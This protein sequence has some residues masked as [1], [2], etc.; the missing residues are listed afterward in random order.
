MSGRDRANVG[1]GCIV[2]GALLVLLAGCTPPLEIGA[3]G[4]TGPAVISLVRHL[5]CELATAYGN[6]VFGSGDGHPMQ[7][8]PDLWKR[9]YD[10]EF[11]AAVDLTLTVTHTQ[12]FNPS[13]SFM[14]PLSA[15]GTV[16]TTPNGNVLGS[17]SSSMF[18]QSLALGFQLDGTQDRNFDVQY[19]IDLHRLVGTIEQ[20][21][22]KDWKDAKDKICQESRGNG[23]MSYAAS[24]SEQGFSGLQGDLD[25]AETINDGLLVLDF[26]G[27]TNIYGT[28]GPTRTADEGGGAGTAIATA[29]QPPAATAVPT[30]AQARG[31]QESKLLDENVAARA[32]ELAGSGHGGGNTGGGAAG[33][34]GNATFSSKI[35]FSV[36]EG[37]N[38]GPNYSI[39]R[40]KGPGGGSG[41]GGGGGAGGAGGGA[42]GGGGGGGQLIS[43]NRTALDS[44]SVTFSPTCRVSKPF[45]LKMSDDAIS[46]KT[47]ATQS[48]WR[49]NYTPTSR[50]RGRFF[51]PTYDVT[52]TVPAPV[53]STGTG[54]LFTDASKNQGLITFEAGGKSFR[55][56]VQVSGYYDTGS[57][58][59]VT[60]SV[61]GK[62]SDPSSQAVV[63]VFSLNGRISPRGTSQW[64]GSITGNVVSSL[65]DTKP[66]ASYWDTIESCDV[67]TSGTT[68]TG[69][70]ARV[71]NAVQQNLLFR[72]PNRLRMLLG[73]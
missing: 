5:N 41:A 71:N 23:P 28:S 35:D 57:D 18:N 1:L 43:A 29:K 22:Q 53:P 8:D 40:F 47:E 54:V 27:R 69:V 45:T 51:P 14:T 37:I 44:L 25:L 34:A 66:T 4:N 26:T 3:G 42:A 13:L 60:A 58:K 7:T 10:D 19:I 49:F 67:L 48:S 63:G 72:L 50:E 62:I 61:N 12:G 32:A 52:I 55:G 16:L 33:Q 15:T 64:T 68:G 21:G 46:F 39:L 20:A 59:V 9:L 38:G 73:Q 65:D 17:S 2:A 24:T 11:V 56:T 30:E 6:V 31:D 36:V 70:Q